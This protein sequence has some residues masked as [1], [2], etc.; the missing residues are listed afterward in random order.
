V[1]LYY[2]ILKTARQTIPDPEGQELPDE[3]AARLHA[4]TVAQQLMRNRELNTRNWRIEVCDDY[5]QPVFEL[6]FADVDA[7]LDNLPPYLQ[8]RVGDVVRTSVALNE[9]IAKMQATL[10]DVR[11]TLG[12]ADTLLAFVPP[13][14][15][16]GRSE[17]REH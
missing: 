17:H 16:G 8:A 1:Q 10:R 13:A 5:L 2:F 15:R 14:L 9:A 7:T 11:K 3:T 6:F 4:V 12:R